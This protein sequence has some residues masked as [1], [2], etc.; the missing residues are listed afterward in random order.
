MQFVGAK[1]VDKLKDLI[2]RHQFQIPI[3]AMHGGKIVARSDI[4]SFRKN[5]TAK[6]YG[7]DRTRKDKLLK[8]QKKGKKKMREFGRVNI[9]QEVFIDLYKQE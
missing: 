6:L 5:V 9:P 3:Q 7:G 2:P 8:K 4:K 1:L